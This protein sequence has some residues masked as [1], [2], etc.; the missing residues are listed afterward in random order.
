M[1]DIGIRVTPNSDQLVP[2]ASDVNVTYTCTVDGG[3]SAVWEV[4]GRQILGAEQASNFA[5][6]G[7]FVE[8]LN[9][10]T[11]VIVISGEARRDASRSVP[12]GVYLLCVA[13][14]KLKGTPGRM[15]SV[16]TYGEC[17][18][19]NYVSELGSC[20]FFCQWKLFWQPRVSV[21]QLTA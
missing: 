8:G 14:E 19:L 10:N 7:I 6:S 12:P 4:R 9:S 2:F 17:A 1:S 15:Y 21:C 3:R 11:S 16:I 20:H 5:E 13:L 18:H